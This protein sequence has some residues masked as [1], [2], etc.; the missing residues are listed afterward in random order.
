[1]MMMMML[2]KMMTYIQQN[3]LKQKNIELQKYRKKME[4][5]SKDLQRMCTVVNDIIKNNN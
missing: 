1:M 5:L 2:P 3:F 4:N